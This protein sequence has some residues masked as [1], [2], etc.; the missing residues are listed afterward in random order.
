[1][2]VPH[3]IHAELERN[4]TLSAEH[5]SKSFLE[6]LTERQAKAAEW[7][8]NL[9]S[10][11]P[12]TRLRFSWWRKALLHRHLGDD[13]QRF[14]SDKT[15]QDRRNT[16]EAE[17]RRR[18]GKKRASVAW[19]LNDVLTGFWAGGKPSFIDV[20]SMMAITTQVC[21]RLQGIRRR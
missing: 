15:F 12:G 11:N 19:A 9:K 6:K 1:M 13:M 14:G 17:W 18:S 2:S 5:L 7:N 21:S 20:L 3:N 16:L 10:V 8:A 4:L